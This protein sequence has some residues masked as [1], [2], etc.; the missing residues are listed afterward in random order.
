MRLRDKIALVTGAGTGIGKAIALT[1][2]SEGAKVVVTDIDLESA[3]KT[4]EEITDRGGEVMA[5][6]MD[7][8]KKEEIENARIAAL[9]R[10]NRIDILVNNA[11]VSTMNWAVDLTE[12]EWDY[13]MNVNAKGVFLCSQVFVK[14]MIRQGSGGKVV[15]VASMAG[16]RGAILLAHYCASKSAVIGFTK[17]LALEVA[18]YKIN[19]NAVCPGFVM[20][21]MQEREL[22]WEAR[23][24][25]LTP[26]QV[27]QE[28]LK[29]IPLGRLETPEDVAIV[30]A[31]LASSEADY[32][33]GQAINVTGGVETH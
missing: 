10:F 1:L 15:N 9:K 33:T 13:N 24:R 8:T 18:S 6:K 23:L 7:V 2:C 27:K 3:K 5:L 21:S 16:K 4:A 14:Q 25:G 29:A 30:V 26:E 11:G 32:M 12:E 28:Y 20:T 22:Q 17:A 19:V 31:F